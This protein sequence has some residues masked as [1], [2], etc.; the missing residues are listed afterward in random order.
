VLPTLGGRIQSRIVFLAIIGGIITLILTPIL[1]G[2]GSLTLSQ[3]YET[4]FSILITVIVLGVIWEFIYHLI[5]QWRWEKDW[6]TFFGFITAINEGIVVY[7]LVNSG[8]WPGIA[9]APGQAHHVPLA[10]FLIDFLVIWIC[11]WLWVNGPMRVV[12]IRWRFHG[13]RLV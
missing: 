7:L 4:T 1:P 3:K 9:G 13:G 8:H 6:P 10:A 2:L 11:V 12:N 5:M